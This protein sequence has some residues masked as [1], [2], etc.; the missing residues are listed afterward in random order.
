[1]IN[2]HKVRR[3]IV[4][5]HVC[6][7]HHHLHHRHAYH[8]VSRQLVP[9]FVGLTVLAIGVCFGFNCGY[10]INPARDFAPRLFTGELFVFR[11]L[12]A[13]HCSLMSQTGQLEFSAL[14]GWGLEVFTFYNHWSE[15]Y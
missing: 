14:T 3:Q 15:L 6:H 4:P 2:D 9:L 13:S 12:W 10:A 5:I 11:L 1:M 8:Q 7:H